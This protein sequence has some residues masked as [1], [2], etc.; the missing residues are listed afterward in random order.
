MPVTLPSPSSIPAPVSRDV[1]AFARTLVTALRALQMYSDR[2]PN[3]QAAAGHCRTAIAALAAHDQLTIGVTPHGLLVNGDPQPSDGRTREACTLLN[4]KDILRLR[5]KAAPEAADVLDFLRLLTVDADTLRASGGPA[6]VWE[7]TGQ[8]W[9]EL[10]QINY[11]RLLT[12]AALGTVVTADRNDGPGGH[13]RGVARD[14]E[15]W[16]SL[17]RA[18][19]QGSTPIDAR[20]EHRLMEIAHSAEAIAALVA[21]A[22]N[23]Q[24]GSGTALDATRAAAV[25]STYQRLTTFVELQAPGDAEFV[26]NNIASAAGRTDPALFMRAVSEAAESGVGVDVVSAV[27]A[28]FTDQEASRLLATALAAEG[29]ASSRMAAALTTLVPDAERRERV[30][31]LARQHDSGGG[32]ADAGSLATAWEALD[33]LLAGPADA[34]YVSRLYG[35]TIEYAEARSNRL[36]LDAPQKLDQWTRSISSESLRALSTTLLL[37]LFSLETDEARARDLARDL[38]AVAEDLLLAND[39]DEAAR[40]V[41]TLHDAGTEGEA[42]AE[43]ARAGLDVL[44]QSAAIG[45]AAAAVAEFDDDQFDAF[46]RICRQLGPDVSPTLVAAMG[47]ASDESAA[48]RLR[49]LVAEAGPSAIE[50]AVA[51]A[52]TAATEQ[53]AVYL[54]LIATLGGPR[55]FAA[56]Q[57]FARSPKVDLAALATNELLVMED[58]AAWKVLAWLVSTGDEEHRLAAVERIASTRHPKAGGLLALALGGLDPLGADW[59]ACRRVIQGLQITGARDAVVSLADTMRAMSWRSWRRALWLKRE[60]IDLL[61]RTDTPDARAAL[62]AA[63]RDGD[64][65]LRRLAG[66]AR[67]TRA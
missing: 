67:R 50:A 32:S 60:A 29:K 43:A 4:D 62:D 47:T 39:V 35:E 3:T 25:L 13:R 22:A 55:S 15:I 41:G 61:A 59:A 1:A 12:G 56:L 45:E 5:F 38:G 14:D 21:D 30:L 27:G 17:V 26:V 49:S 7:S 31:R 28:R 65:L 54:R 51:A 18:M 24:T 16:G 52:E 8:P 42:R 34:D 46:A 44:R 36:R 66:A 53:A 23:T 11:D 33:S 10:D 2:H 19:S 48:D 40:V 58:P 57:A 9:L 63:A 64:F 37:D 20:A 6:A